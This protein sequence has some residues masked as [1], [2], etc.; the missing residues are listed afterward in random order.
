MSRRA[1]RRLYVLG[2]AV[3]A[4]A[5]APAW[6]PPLLSGL[7]VF[8]V[9]AV[10]V[11]GTRYVPPD[12]IARLAS[13]E[14]GAS[15][16]DEPGRWERR[17]RGHPLVR[18]ARVRRSGLRRVEIR[19]DEREPVALAALP[20]VVPVSAEGEVLPLDPAEAALDLPLLT[21]PARVVDGRLRGG[22]SGELLGLL[23]RLRARDPE[24]VGQVSELRALPGGGIEVL[25]GVGAPAGRI[26]LPSSE[27]VRALRRVELALGRHGGSGAG[28]RV[29]WADARFDGQVVLGGREDS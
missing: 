2:V 24:F 21:G 10:E 22:R 29:G 25:L 6:A 5:S 1:R 3:L 16:W 17:V 12:E 11:V 8:R 26:L 18:D 28:A 15:V 20:E 23:V 19:V 4:G 13:V 7:P 14:E 27:P 9:E